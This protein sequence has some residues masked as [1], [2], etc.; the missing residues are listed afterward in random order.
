MA[1]PG[2][3][4]WDPARARYTDGAG[5]V[6][7]LRQTRAALDTALS[8]S[9]ARV[10]SLCEDYRRGRIS[11]VDWELGMR[12]EVKVT[13]LYSM[14]LGAGGWPSVNQAHYDRVGPA[15]RDQYKYLS[16]F[17]R[18]LRRRERGTD[19]RFFSRAADYVQAGRG[20]YHRLERY[21]QRQAGNN[22]EQSVLGAADHCSSCV[23]EAAR[24][25]VSI[26][27]LIPVGSR[28]CLS[29]CHCHIEYQVRPVAAAGSGDDP[30]FAFYH[31]NA[32]ATADDRV[33]Y[34]QGRLDWMAG[35]V[36]PGWK[37]EEWVAKRGLDIPK[38]QADLEAWRKIGT[39]LRSYDG[40][41][42]VK[43][44][45]ESVPKVATRTSTYDSY[46][47]DLFYVIDKQ[48]KK[49][50]REVLKATVKTTRSA[51]LERGATYI[52][53]DT[54]E[55]VIEFARRM[56]VEMSIQGGRAELL[57]VA[58]DANAALVDVWQARGKM[59]R[60][61]RIVDDVPDHPN[62]Y[63]LYDPNNDTVYLHTRIADDKYRTER[64]WEHGSG[65][66]SSASPR[67]TVDHELAHA[68]HWHTSG[69]RGEIWQTKLT[70]AE[71][72]IIRARVSRYGAT[73]ASEM[74]AE[75]YSG[76]ING[77]VYDDEVMAIYRKYKGPNIPVGKTTHL[78]AELGVPVPPVTDAVP[79][80]TTAGGV[81]TVI[82]QQSVYRMNDEQLFRWF[83]SLP[84]EDGAVVLSR[85]TA[86][87]R[88]A[89]SAARDRV[90]DI[91]QTGKY[92]KF[93]TAA[94]AIEDLPEDIAAIRDLVEK[95]PEYRAW[96]RS[97]DGDDIAA[98]AEYRQAYYSL[99][100]GVLRGQDLAEVVA[101]SKH[102]TWS[103]ALRP[104]IQRMIDEVA[105]AV[106][107]AIASVP[108]LS[109]DFV[110]HRGARSAELV[111]LIDG[112]DIVG[113]VISDQAFTSATFS[114]Q[115]AARF[116]GRG[117]DAVLFE[118]ESPTGTKVLPVDALFPAGIRGEARS[119]IKDKGDELEALFQR[120]T[121]FRVLSTRKNASGVRV[122]RMRVI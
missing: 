8:Q 118:I 46:R 19:G 27:T 97:L 112:G 24:G 13:H 34:A 71:E 47:A 62:V 120:G 70:E 23:N 11:I 59:P 100:N 31:E 36:P 39:E 83:K 9:D 10:R 4:D 61:V 117:K 90:R 107:R 48:A 110:L 32:I 40:P 89:W 25:W 64:V 50:A 16:R 93:S 105:P 81:R 42:T 102:F 121:N 38:F 53:V 98:V 69:V 7:Q 95:S 76:V 60:A 101:K 44:L 26:G 54:V 91:F 57:Q 65:F 29:R 82:N 43:K 73:D 122:I 103:P 87:E 80:T 41:R 99:I 72:R 1:R 45:K 33:R 109:R 108:G 68:A 22:E 78:T 2:A 111:R 5:R 51:L 88:E 92:K 52:P 86:G 79:T 21:T 66:K 77:K 55:E 49:A 12:R 17:A 20:T 75:V 58:N 115:V 67:H 104:T 14:A 116:A 3:Y 119:K 28:R 56:G 94:S 35:P 6:V 18:Q 37:A 15:I 63:G 30:E 84:K 85:M 113:K 74:V 114:R 106:E 96:V